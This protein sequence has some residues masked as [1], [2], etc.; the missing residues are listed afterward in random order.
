M[1]LA[2][3]VQARRRR[4]RMFLTIPGCTGWVSH[5]HDLQQSPQA[6]TPPQYTTTVHHN[7]KALYKPGTALCQPGLH[8]PHPSTIFESLVSKQPGTA[9]CHPGVIMAHPW[10]EIKPY[11][12]YSRIPYN[13]NPTYMRILLYYH[14]I[15]HPA[16]P[17]A[18]HHIRRVKIPWKPWHY[19]VVLLLVY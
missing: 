2:V 9:L 11:F 12:L 17:K 13:P 10:R 7:S 5:F 14:L 19:R 4:G 18:T 16:R 1:N 15:M 3:I 8:Y 6:R